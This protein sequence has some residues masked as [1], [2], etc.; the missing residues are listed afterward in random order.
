[1]DFSPAD[2]RLFKRAALIA[3]ALAIILILGLWTARVIG[4]ESIWM[5]A[6]AI[7]YLEFCVVFAFYNACKLRAGPSRDSVFR[8]LSILFWNYFVITS[9]VAVPVIIVV[10]GLVL[11]L[12]PGISLLGGDYT[13]MLLSP[14]WWFLLLLIASLP[15]IFYYLAVLGLL[16]CQAIMFFVHKFRQPSAGVRASSRR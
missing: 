3:L 5:A 16:I 8:F 13:E 6:L 12:L 1:M 11:Y 15:F 4:W 10:V 7:F 14:G 9:A 2:T